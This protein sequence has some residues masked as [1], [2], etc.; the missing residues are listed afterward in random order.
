MVCANP[1]GACVTLTV[2]AF[3]CGG[4][5]SNWSPRSGIGVELFWHSSHTP[6]LSYVVRSVFSPAGLRSGSLRRSTAK[7]TPVAILPR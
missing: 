5:M 2:S 1:F 4:A 3:G 6:G 7:F